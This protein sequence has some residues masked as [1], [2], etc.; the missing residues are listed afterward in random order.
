MDSRTKNEKTPGFGD[1]ENRVLTAD[2]AA[3]AERA[4][5]PAQQAAVREVAEETGW[6]S[7]P[8]T[9]TQVVE[10]PMDAHAG[11][12]MFF[13]TQAP[14]SEPDIDLD[15]IVESR[16]VECQ[17]LLQLPAFRAARHFYQ[18]WSST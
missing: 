14:T 15:E 13:T 3:S 9:L 11:T 18:T 2:V 5:R 17:E 6:T 8:E 10:Q 12:L 7:A 4:V 1:T 16:W